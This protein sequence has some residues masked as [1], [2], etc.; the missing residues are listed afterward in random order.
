[1]SDGLSEM[2]EGLHVGFWRCFPVALF[3]VGSAFASNH[4][5]AVW[6]RT[7]TE[8]LRAMVVAFR[9]QCLTFVA[10]SGPVRFEG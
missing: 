1:V 4:T 10:E 6:S 3:N 8:S 7:S 5:G 2:W 9:L